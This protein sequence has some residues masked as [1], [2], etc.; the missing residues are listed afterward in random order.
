MIISRPSCKLPMLFFSMLFMSDSALILLSTLSLLRSPVVGAA[1][2]VLPGQASAGCGKP[3]IADG[4]TRPVT[5]NST[6]CPNV[7]PTRNYSIHLPINYNPDNPTALIIS[8]HGA[9]ETPSYHETESQLSNVSYNP[10]MIVVYP[11]GVHV[12][13]RLS[14]CPKPCRMRA[15]EPQLQP[16]RKDT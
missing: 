6:C 12:S 13:F 16:D 8:Y 5:I 10:D 15:A 14:H 9:G 3:H 7:T 1:V 4:K 11:A 2:L